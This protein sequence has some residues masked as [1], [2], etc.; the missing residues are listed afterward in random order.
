MPKVTGPKDV[1]AG[2][3]QGRRKQNGTDVQMDSIYC[4]SMAKKKPKGACGP[5]TEQNNTSLTD[6]ARQGGGCSGLQGE[7]VEVLPRE[8]MT[9]AR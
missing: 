4:S 2:R 1:L 9:E 6:S 3:H 7:P 5:T 8:V